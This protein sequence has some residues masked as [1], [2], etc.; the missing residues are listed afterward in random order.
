LKTGSVQYLKRDFSTTLLVSYLLALDPFVSVPDL[1]DEPPVAPKKE[2]FPP[3]LFDR[4]DFVA[5]EDAVGF[6]ER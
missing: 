4:G 2:R 6:S 3:G 1:T 5:G